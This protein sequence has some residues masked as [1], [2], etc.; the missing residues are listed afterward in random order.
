MTGPFWLSP[1]H[2]VVLFDGPDAGAFLQSQLTNDVAALTEGAWQWQ[3]YC[4]AKGRLVATF[5]LARL[6]QTRYA[7]VVHDSLAQ[8]LVN[9]LTIFR[10][11]SKV[12]LLIEP[13][14]ALAFA[15]PGTPPQPKALLATWA[16]APGLTFAIAEAQGQGLARAGAEQVEALRLAL[17]RAHI[18]EVTAATT[19]H[20]VPQMI[21][22]DRVTPGG[23][24]SFSKGCYPGQEV[25][26]RAHYRGA[27]KKH[28]ERV[29]LPL[30]PVRSPGQWVVLA[31]GR[32]AEICNIARDTQ[33]QLALVVVQ[34][35][36]SS[37][38]G[39]S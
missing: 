2:A 38:S 18:P 35:T 5:A 16:V 24:V 14:L 25:V 21:G 29:E 13:A 4:T 3:G 32:E 34:G 22:W 26:A 31:D 30:E 33:A 27:V 7:A 37:T 6:G 19:E 10:L 23:G 36:E 20:F 12:S 1:S 11:R 17:I 28:L 8:A 9:R 39:S 15:L